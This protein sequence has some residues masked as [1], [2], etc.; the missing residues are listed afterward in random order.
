MHPIAGTTLSPP[1]RQVRAKFSEARV[2][3]GERRVDPYGFDLN[4]PVPSGAGGSWL[5]ARILMGA[6]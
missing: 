3:R 6:S 2:D 5:R 4:Q 1:R